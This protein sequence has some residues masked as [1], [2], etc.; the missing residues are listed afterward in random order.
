MAFHFQ[1]QISTQPGK[2]Y[3]LSGICPRLCRN[4]QSQ[5][6]PLEGQ[7]WAHTFR[8]QE[9]QC[10]HWW[11]KCSYTVSEDP[12]VV[13][14]PISAKRPPESHSEFWFLA[15]GVGS[16]YW[17]KSELPE[18]PS[19]SQRSWILGKLLSICGPQE[20]RVALGWTLCQRAAYP[21]RGEKY[22]P[23]C[24]SQQLQTKN[25]P[26]QDFFFWFLRSCNLWLSKKP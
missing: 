6:F 25:I 19:M 24:I 23:K 9:N 21:K 20:P 22:V 7:F 1:A 14:K 16:W 2:F 11:G 13:I 17:H 18:V 3:N 10:G 8:V 12:V 26:W 5:L 4:S 15:T